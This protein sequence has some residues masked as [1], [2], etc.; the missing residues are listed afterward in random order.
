[1]NVNKMATDFEKGL[2]E[3]KFLKNVRNSGLLFAFDLHN[4]IDINDFS[5]KLF[6]NEMLCNPTGKN[7][8]RLRPH[9]FATKK[10]ID[11]GLNRINDSIKAIA[12]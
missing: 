3:I 4:K 5:S 2:K 12:K 7:T 10:E 6:K 9:L 8:I 1:M 11:E